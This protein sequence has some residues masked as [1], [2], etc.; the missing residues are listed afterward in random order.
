MCFHVFNYR[1]VKAAKE[2]VANLKQ[3]NEQNN[4]SDWPCTLA[5]LL[6]LED[7]QINFK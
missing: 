1:Q 4:V 5:L 6:L 3:L 7:A 2:R